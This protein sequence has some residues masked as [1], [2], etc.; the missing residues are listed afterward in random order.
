MLFLLKYIEFIMGFDEA[1]IQII[2]LF[3]GLE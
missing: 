1:D 2:L 3:L